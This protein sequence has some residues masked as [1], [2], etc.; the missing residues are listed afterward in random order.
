M[1]TQATTPTQSIDRMPVVTQKT[2]VKR[3]SIY[4]KINPASKYYDPTFPKPFKLSKRSI[5]FYAHEV[6]AWIESRR[7]IGA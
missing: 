3:S 1:V 6:Q 2:G 5:G 4:N 7:E